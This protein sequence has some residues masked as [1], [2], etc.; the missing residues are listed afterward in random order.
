M[1]I[2]EIEGIQ[3]S[4]GEGKPLAGVFGSERLQHRVP[5]GS[6]FGGKVA[7]QIVETIIGRIIHR[8]F[9]TGSEEQAGRGVGL[10]LDIGGIVD[11]SL[12]VSV[13]ISR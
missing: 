10:T 2:V 11:A 1:G 7:A 9:L 8:H 13:G 4:R 6:G 5:E 12:V 3:Q